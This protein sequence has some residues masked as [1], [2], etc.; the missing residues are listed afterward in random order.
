M[1]AHFRLE[2]VAATGVVV[3]SYRHCRGKKETNEPFLFYFMFFGRDSSII[4]RVHF[5]VCFP[6]TTAR[7]VLCTVCWPRPNQI[8]LAI[9]VNHVRP[10]T[11][12]EISTLF[13]EVDRVGP[14]LMPDVRF[15]LYRMYLKFVE[16]IYLECLKERMMSDIK[17][18][19]VA[20]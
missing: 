17:F 2:S 12:V 13:E 9:T 20:R 10:Q 6:A 14:C 1:V 15:V 7:A 19:A 18:E 3:L 4:S 5:R 16:S 11:V 8:I